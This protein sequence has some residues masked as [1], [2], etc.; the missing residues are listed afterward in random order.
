MMGTMVINMGTTMGA[1]FTN[2]MLTIT[3]EDSREPMEDQMED[4]GEMDM[5]DITITMDSIA[6]ILN[7]RKTSARCSADRKSTRLNSSH[8]GES[9]M[10]SSA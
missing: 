5:L 8:S 7:P 2:P 3:M 9:R 6:Q 4:T 10:P 1:T